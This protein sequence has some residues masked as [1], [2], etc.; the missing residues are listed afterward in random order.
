MSEYCSVA[1]F[2]HFLWFFVVFCGFSGHKT[3]KDFTAQLL[4]Q[5]GSRLGELEICH[6]DMFEKPLNGI[7]VTDVN[8]PKYLFQVFDC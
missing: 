5:A 3:L 6:L 8:A 4:M 7:L 1:S 2:N